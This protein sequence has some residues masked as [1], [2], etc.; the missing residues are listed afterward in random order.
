MT[1]YAPPPQPLA[2]FGPAFAADPRGHYRALRAHGPLAPVRIA[3]DIEAMLVTDYQAAID[4]LRDTHTFS[5]DPRAWQATVPPDSPV[6]PVLGH[7]PTALFSDGA[8]HA[9]YRQAINDSLALIEPHVLRAE[10]ARVARQLIGRFAGSGSADLIAEYARRLPMHI[11]VTWFGADPDDGERIVDGI[12][13]MMNSAADAAAAYADLVDVV[14][15]LVA[16]RRARPRRDLTSYFLAHPAGLD[17]D[18]TVRQITLV[19]SAGNDPMT[20]LIGNATLHMLTDE[21]YAGSLH[22]GAMTAHEAINE[23]LWRDPPLANLA[24]H[25]PRHDTEFHGVRLRAGQLVLVSYAAANSQSAAPAS[26]DGVRSGAGA[27]LAWSAG[28]H[29]CPAKQP[30]LLIATTAIE[31][32]TSLLCDAE[33]AVPAEELLW[34][35]G[36]F[37]R[38]LAH[39]PIRF[40][41]LDAGTAP[42]RP[43]TVADPADVIPAAAI[44]S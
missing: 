12:A 34:R 18:E 22:G 41:P 25:Y 20:N 44:D 5:K 40:T 27:H 33:L 23:V 28:P 29:R 17:N 4:L 1:T 3:P 14:T 16:D 39:L 21:R 6:L 32:L 2:L 13:G 15:R 8:V 43:V 19:M 31:Q 26:D 9:R 38:A 24:A 7:R 10:V 35:P 11:F 30:A 37:H 42:N 36:P